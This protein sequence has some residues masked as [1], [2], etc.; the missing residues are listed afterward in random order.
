MIGVGGAAQ[1][2]CVARDLRRRGREGGLSAREG[3]REWLRQRRLVLARVTNHGKGEGVR[4]VGQHHA[5]GVRP[6]HVERV[7]HAGSAAVVHEPY[8]R[9]AIKAGERVL[10]GVVRGGTDSRAGYG[11]EAAEERDKVIVALVGSPVQN[12]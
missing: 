5:L 1:L 4:A 3:V 8:G 10:V 6:H 2:A 9:A 7:A 11:A 12:V